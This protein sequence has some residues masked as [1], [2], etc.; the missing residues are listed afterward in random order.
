MFTN[1]RISKIVS[2]SSISRSEWH[3]EVPSSIAGL[4]LLALVVLG[5]A[6]P[7]HAQLGLGLLPMRVE[8][9]MA[10]GQQYSG[11]LKLSSQSGSTMRIRSE[12]DDFYIDDN[13]A[14]QFERDVPREAANSCKKWLTLNPM[15]IE[16]ENGGFLNVRY[17]I[18]LPEDVPEGSYNCA[19]GFLTMPAAG[20]TTNGIGMQM[21]V[22]IVA[23]IYVQVG[24]PAVVGRLKEIKL[25]A[26]PAPPP[27]PVA[28]GK[29]VPSSP[30]S[31]APTP[32]SA[33]HPP[34][35]PPHGAWQA[36][37]VMENTGKMYYR[38]T[39]K[40]EV[41]DDSGKTVETAD[42]PSL[43]VLRERDQR[44]TL[45]LKTNLEA[46]RYKLRARVDIGTGEIQEGSAEV[47]VEGAAQPASH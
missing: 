32:D 29:V 39:G 18:R 12:T 34:E 8:V 38:P 33:V 26:Q 27:G 4:C 1:S 11:T 41:L 40:L 24:S 6:A 10:P 30:D 3:I 46:G 44:F 42:L 28:A 22:R 43:P 21:A 15:E 37:L 47:N 31:A 5:V 20:Q 17:T 2:H 16:L 13:T 25:E 7:A 45:P 35:A 23:A 19:A 14:P 9:R 36:V